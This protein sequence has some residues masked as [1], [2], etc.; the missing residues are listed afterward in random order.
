MVRSTRVFLFFSNQLGDVVLGSRRSVV[1]VAIHFSPIFHRIHSFAA[2]A[3][4]SFIYILQALPG[5]VMRRPCCFLF[6]LVGFNNSIQVEKTAID[7]LHKFDRRL[8][9]IMTLSLF[10]LSGSAAQFG[11]EAQ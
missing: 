3:V 4:V 9:V 1:F 6:L 10:C 5:I 2:P 8:L 11:K 7:I